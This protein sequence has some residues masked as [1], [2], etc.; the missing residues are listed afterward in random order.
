MPGVLEAHPAARAVLVGGGPSRYVRRLK[1]MARSIGDG[2]SVT[3]AGPQPWSRV[4]SWYA[5]GDVFAMPTR[6]RFGGLETEGFGM[7]YL[8]AAACGVPAVGGLAGGT[9]D[10]VIE[11]ETGHLVDGGDPGAV[12][13]A[14]NRLFD[15]PVKLR[16]MGESARARVEEHFTWDAVSAKLRRAI[17]THCS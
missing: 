12:A 2:R 5:S 4:P 16:T 3:F 6:D 8:E 10:A 17:Q 1:Q 14:I 13:A 11:G 7:V 15:D 9:H